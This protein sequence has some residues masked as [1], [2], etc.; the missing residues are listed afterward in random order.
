MLHRLRAAFTPAAVPEQHTRT[1]LSRGHMYGNLNDASTAAL[2]VSLRPVRATD[3]AQ[4][5]AARIEDQK[6]SLIHI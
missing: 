1:V 4:W 6:L 2:P 5:S 3:G